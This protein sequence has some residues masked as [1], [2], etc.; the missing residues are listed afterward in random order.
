MK[1]IEQG[2]TF[3]VNELLIMLV[4]VKTTSTTLSLGGSV[5]SQAAAMA[6]SGTNM[7]RESSVEYVA[8]TNIFR[9]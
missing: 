7:R 8:L 6:R 4:G 9:I 5:A 2:E 1:R 3:T